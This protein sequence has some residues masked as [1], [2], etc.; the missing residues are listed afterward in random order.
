MIGTLPGLG[1]GAGLQGLLVWVAPILLI[2]GSDRTSGEERLLWVLAI[3]FV[4]CLA[5]IFYALLAPLAERP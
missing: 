2:L 5:W 4:S 1:V 3:V